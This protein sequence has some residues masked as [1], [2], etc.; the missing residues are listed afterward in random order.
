MA[1]P[2]RQIVVAFELIELPE[3]R[4]FRQAWAG[5]S[6]DEIVAEKPVGLGTFWCAADQPRDPPLRKIYRTTEV[7]DEARCCVCD[8]AIHEL[9]EMFS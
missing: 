3:Q 8:I 6:V 9:Q 4:V 7:S 5:M 1:R 2:R